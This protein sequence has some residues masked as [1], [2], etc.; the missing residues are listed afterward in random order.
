MLTALDGLNRLFS[1][2]SPWL[3]MARRAGLAAA[4]A[5]DPIKEFFMRRAVGQR[6]GRSHP[7]SRAA[8]RGFRTL[9]ASVDPE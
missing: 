1:N 8:R 2:D 5:V 3:G 6:A 9:R 7:R 4:N